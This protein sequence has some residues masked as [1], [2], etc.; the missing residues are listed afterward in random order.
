MKGRKPFRWTKARK[1]Y[2]QL[3]TQPTGQ[4]TPERLKELLTEAMNERARREKWH[5]SEYA[6]TAAAM[7]AD[8]DEVARRCGL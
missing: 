1:Y 4:Y 6:M 7:S 3:M 8:I 2:R 5:A